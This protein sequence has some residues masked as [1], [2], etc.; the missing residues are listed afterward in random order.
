[1]KM[2][3]QVLELSDTIKLKRNLMIEVDK[4][5]RLSQNYYSSFDGKWS[6]FLIN[7]GEHITSCNSK[8]NGKFLKSC[9]FSEN[10]L[11][12]MMFFLKQCS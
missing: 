8:I 12:I 11:K 7:F 6:D 2:K 5:I 10:K 4:S 3:Q 9:S 1:M